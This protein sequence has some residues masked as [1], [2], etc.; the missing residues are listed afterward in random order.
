MSAST[1]PGATTGP[2]KRRRFERMA[3]SR[4]A[5]TVHRKA[6][7][8]LKRERPMDYAAIA[9]DVSETGIRLA[10]SEPLKRGETVRLTAAL[11]PWRE[12]L[13]GEARVVWG[14]DGAR[15]RGEFLAG[16]EWMRLDPS[17]GEAIGR[18]RRNH[19]G[20][21]NRIPDQVAG[22][23]GPPPASMPASVLQRLRRT[24]GSEST[25]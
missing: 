4:C 17:S 8:F 11:P 21:R 25:P 5:V 10:L 13:C 15:V 19:A 24:L 16:L 9:V 12:E 14:A 18:L 7:W 20:R 1:G 23:G 3:L 6:G 2:R 22:G